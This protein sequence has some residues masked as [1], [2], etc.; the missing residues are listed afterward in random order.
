MSGVQ[1]KLGSVACG[2]IAAEVIGR[3]QQRGD[4]EQQPQE[5]CKA[6]RV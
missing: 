5:S 6:F 1:D 4:E 3:E 2:C